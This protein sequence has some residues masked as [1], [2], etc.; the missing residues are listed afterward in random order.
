MLNINCPFCGA[1]MEVAECCR[2]EVVNCCQCQRE[3]VVPNGVVPPKPVIPSGP[4]RMTLNSRQ[5]PND[6]S[7]NAAEKYPYVCPVCGT[8]GSCSEKPKKFSTYVLL[9]WLLGGFGAGDFY[10]GKNRNGCIKLAITIVCCIVGGIVASQVW[11]MIDL[12]NIRRD[13]NGNP[14][15]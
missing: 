11:S 13:A 15:I 6:F 3:I 8:S 14:L 10:I 5:I 1:E 7:N 12:C 4:P 9:S 2:G